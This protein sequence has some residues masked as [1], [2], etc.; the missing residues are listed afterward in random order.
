MSEQQQAQPEFPARQYTLEAPAYVRGTWTPAGAKVE[1]AAT[2]GCTVL[3][4]AGSI[5]RIIPCTET[6]AL[7]AIEREQR[8]ELKLINAPPAL[9]LAAAASADESEEDDSEDDDDYEDDEQEA[10]VNERY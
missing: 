2:A 7:L 1:R 4:G 10:S 8:A 5:Y 9:A 3:V 6:A